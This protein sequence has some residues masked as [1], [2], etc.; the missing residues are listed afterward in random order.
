MW[1]EVNWFTFTFD[2]DSVCIP[3]VVSCRDWIS[4]SEVTA[5][6]GYS[7][8]LYCDCKLPSGVYMVRYRNCSHENQLSLVLKLKYGSWGNNTYDPLKP[9]SHFQFRWNS[10]SE[11]YDLMILNITD[12]PSTTVKHKSSGLWMKNS[13]LPHLF[14]DM[15]MPPQESY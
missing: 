1:I 8:T 12:S 5:H 11:S 14:T 13:S 15:A 3:A 10:S 7:I 6:V 9:S 4:G 2:Y